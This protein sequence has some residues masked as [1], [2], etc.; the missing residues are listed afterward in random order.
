MTHPK[1]GIAASLLLAGASAWPGGGAIHVADFGAV[2]DDGQCD[3]QAIDTA[4]RTAIRTGCR[5]VDFATGTYVMAVPGTPSVRD[6]G[7]IVIRSVTNLALVGQTNS[8]GRPA[9]RIERAIAPGNDVAPPSQIRIDRSSRISVRN[10]VLANNPPL[11]T[12]AKVVAV[13]KE[14][15]EVVVEVLDGLPAYDGMRGASAHAWDLGTGKLLRFGT[16]P[17][18]ATLTIGTK[19]DAYWKAVPGTNERRLRMTGAGFAAK[20]RVGDG[21]S[22]HRKA[23]G[24]AQQISVMHSSDLVFENIAI[25]NAF[26]IGMLAGYNRNLSLRGIRCEPEGGNLAV[27]ARDGLHLSNTSGDLLVEDCTFKGLRMDPLVIRRTF[28]RVTA[29]DPDGRVFIAPGYTVPTGDAIRFWAGREPSD[30]V[31][32]TCGSVKGRGI[33]YQVASP[34]PDGVVTGTP[35]SFLTHSLRSG[36]I[37][38]CIFEDN[39]GS[40]IVNFEENV[41][42]ESCT[43]D[44]NAYQ[45][46]YGPNAESGGF[47]RNNVFRDN[48]CKDVPWIDIARR[49]QPAALLVHSISRYFRDP[50]YNGPLEITGN[51]FRNPQGVA[52]ATAIDIRNARGVI[53]RGNTFEGFATP[54]VVDPR[55]TADIRAGR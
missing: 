47:T 4:V 49:G 27:G 52:A 34:L 2:P 24:E 12:T 22:W 53:I 11:G 25:P 54:V 43:F 20:V 44:N 5:R 51:V 3:M 55:T 40:A 19:V 33:A 14:R 9:T 30:L 39:F 8:A 21:I 48:V 37:R 45:I 17:T 23:D 18:E 7:Y 26:N 13:D 46:K 41:T 29:L 15:D 32:R 50:M 10:L 28:G 1:L 6:G 35:V 38:N 42:V 36:V 31:V 16:T